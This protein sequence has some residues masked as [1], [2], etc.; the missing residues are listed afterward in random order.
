MFI[1]IDE[2]DRSERDGE[3]ERERESGFVIS[4]CT[5]MSA[6]RLFHAAMMKHLL[7]C[8]VSVTMIMMC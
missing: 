3:R 1:I 4:M 8:F 6:T 7:N 5:M 2:R